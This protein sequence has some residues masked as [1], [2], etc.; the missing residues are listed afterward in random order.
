MTFA[1]RKFNAS[2]GSDQSSLNRT[3][4]K[5]LK[6]R[7]KLEREFFERG[8]NEQMDRTLNGTHDISDEKKDLDKTW[9]PGTTPSDSDED[10][11]AEMEST[12]LRANSLDKTWAP[13]KLDISELEQNIASTS[14]GVKC[15]YC[16][17]FFNI[18][19]E[20]FGHI[21]AIH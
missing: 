7:G 6:K 13:G 10:Y 3:P 19:S 18:K 4:V 8:R 12:D 17:T 16:E 20:M 2:Y 9:K 15:N 14:G 11:D 5:Q 21:I 1:K